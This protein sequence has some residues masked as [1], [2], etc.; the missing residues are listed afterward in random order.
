[1]KFSSE[2]KLFMG[3]CIVVILIMLFVPRGL[4]LSAGF[5]AHLGGLRGSVDFEAFENFEDGSNNPCLV[6]FHAKWCGHC[7]KMMPEWKKFKSQ[8][9]SK[10]LA[11]DVD[12]ENKEVMN[13]Y[14]VQGF[15]TIKYFSNGHANGGAQDYTGPRTLKGFQNFVTT[16]L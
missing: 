5:S 1:M 3:V 16:I 12:S 11:I 15:P 4:G 7:K 13:K 14:K 10:V 9:K 8:N 6:L 2:Q